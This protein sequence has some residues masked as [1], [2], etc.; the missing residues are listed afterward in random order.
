MLRLRRGGARGVG[1]ISARSGKHRHLH[2][3]EGAL[4]CTVPPTYRFPMPPRAALSLLGQIAAPLQVLWVQA[5]ILAGLQQHFWG[6]THIDPCQVI[7][8]YQCALAAHALTRWITP[9][10]YHPRM[11][12]LHLEEMDIWHEIKI[13]TL[14]TVGQLQAAEKSLSGWGQYAIVTH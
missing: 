13:D 11:I 10:M 5:H 8:T 2:H 9:S 3:E 1:L 6:W 12:Q 14:V 4:L 7:Y